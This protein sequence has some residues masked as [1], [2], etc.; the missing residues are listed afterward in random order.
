MTTAQ[1]IMYDM[2]VDM[3]IATV[4]ELNLARNLMSG[5]WSEVLHSVLF[6]KTGYRTFEQ[7]FEDEE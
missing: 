5:D 4:D 3:G 1:M 6:I 2:I 7:M